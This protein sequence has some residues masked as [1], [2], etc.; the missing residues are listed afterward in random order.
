MKTP[1]GERLGDREP[2]D[3]GN[4]RRLAGILHAALDC[5]VTVD[6]RSRIL[7]FNPSAEKTFGYRAADVL[8][9][10]MTD[11]IIPAAWRAR[12]R[13]G[14]ARYLA[15]GEPRM[16]GRRMEITALRAD[17]S[18]FPCELTI[19]RLQ[20]EGRPVF[21][22]FL[23]DITDRRAA[24]A[25]IRALNTGLEREVET[26]T[27]ELRLALR[28]L[29][30][31]RERLEAAQAVVQVGDLEFDLERQHSSWSDEAFRL[32][33]FAPAAQPPARTHLRARLHPDD[34]AAW[35]EFT[36]RA[37]QGEVLAP[38]DYRCVRPDGSVR[39]LRAVATLRERT[40]NGAPR[41]VATTLHDITER[42][43]FER[44]LTATLERERELSRLKEEFLHMITHEYRTPLTTMLSAVELLQKYA[45]RLAAPERAGQLD[46]IRRETLRLANL[47]EEVLFLGRSQAGAVELLLQPVRLPAFCR[48]LAREV[49]AA[50]GA[51]RTVRIAAAKLPAR[52]W[53]DLRLLRHV[54][55]NLVHNALKYSTL[56]RPVSVAL[57]SEKGTIVLAVRDRGIGIPARDQPRLFQAFQRSSNVG[58]INGSGIGLVVVKRC[59]DLLG[60]TIKVQSAVGKGTT[61]TVC[62]PHGASPRGRDRAS[63]NRAR[64][65]A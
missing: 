37:E 25:S 27:Q 61:V 35:Q 54:L 63:G 50:L 41:R 17:G 48:E 28:G 30:R 31:T 65:R 60:G 51:D 64:C 14:M 4:A 15:S 44:E 42:K 20:D 29:E 39:W 8:G 23:R 9:R 47:V 21:T 22:A 11:L 12:H 18:E 26:R 10:C 1:A 33:G 46:Q 57:R 59:V 7:E 55:T 16:I 19:T 45:D 13:A 34:V 5:I 6:D 56:D 3:S 38:V 58:T 49:A 24:E 36:A 40:A 62:L 32:H 43:A 2:G 53:L 52:V